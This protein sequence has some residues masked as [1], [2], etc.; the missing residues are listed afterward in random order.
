VVLGLQHLH[1]LGI[2]HRDLKSSNILLSAQG[3]PMLADFGFATFA[4]PET[5]LYKLCGTPEFV[6]PE[7]AR[8][9]SY[10][11]AV[12]WW[13]LGIVMCHCLTLAT[14]FEDP[15]GDAG[16]TIQNICDGRL[17]TAVRQHF[18]LGVLVAAACSSVPT[19][20]R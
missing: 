19:C 10:G 15:S 20:A 12:D 1:L 9:L 6:A 16:K 8:G 4:T 5:P 14:P 17:D 7:I 13:S 3:W 2:V 18:Y 11:T